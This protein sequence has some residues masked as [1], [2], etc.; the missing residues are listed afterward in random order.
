MEGSGEWKALEPERLADLAGRLDG[1]GCLAAKAQAA[2][3]KHVMTTYLGGPDAIR[4]V[5]LEVWARLTTAGRPLS[6]ADRQA[7][8]NAIRGAFAP[9]TE[10]LL[11]LEAVRVLC[12]VESLDPLVEEDAA[13]VAY[14]WIS[15][16]ALV[17]AAPREALCHIAGKGVAYQGVPLA[18]RRRMAGLVEGIVRAS[19]EPPQRWQEFLAVMCLWNAVA[20]QAKTQEWTMRGYQAVLGSAEARESVSMATLEELA[21]WL[22]HTMMTGEGKGYPA[23]AEALARHARQGTLNPGSSADDIAAVLGTPETRALLEAELVDARGDPRLGVAK[24]LAWVRRNEGKLRDWNAFVDGRMAGASGDTK[25]LW[26]AAKGWTAALA[27]DPPYPQRRVRWLNEA[28]AAAQS[29][30]ARLV[31]VGEFVGY[32]RQI[33]RPGVAAEML[34]SIKG[35]FGAEAGAVVAGIQGELQGEEQERLAQEAKAGAAA[36]IG[37]TEARIKLF[38]SR[39]ERARSEGDAQAAA[40]IEA[41]IQRLE[42]ELN[43]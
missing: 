22:Y 16:S 25:A 5:G 37:L 15:G 11:V 34:E 29:E 36:E 6:K 12:L 14:T 20:D 28:M 39:L 33:S 3:G 7:W 30:P 10:A 42:Q 38:R 1:L 41:A 35:Q 17:A 19:P 31:I 43:W 2:V 32:Y 27:S 8:A 18:D 40:D 26:L 24:I 23:F 21:H 9:D 4:S 13:E